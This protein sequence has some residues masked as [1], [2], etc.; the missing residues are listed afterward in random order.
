MSRWHSFSSS[1]MAD[2]RARLIPVM[3]LVIIIQASEKVCVI[4]VPCDLYGLTDHMV[5][6]KFPRLHEIM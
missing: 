2:D 3:R 5:S 4:S 1:C 6:G